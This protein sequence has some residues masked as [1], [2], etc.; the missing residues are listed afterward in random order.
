MNKSALIQVLITE[1][2]LRLG[3]STCAVLLDTR[4][5]YVIPTGACLLRSRKEI[6]E[7]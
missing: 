7:Y 1:M 6:C 2:G 3:I 5:R 4:H